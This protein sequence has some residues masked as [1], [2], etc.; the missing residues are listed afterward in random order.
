MVVAR[1]PH[2]WGRTGMGREAGSA[3]PSRRSR[4]ATAVGIFPSRPKVISRYGSSL[5]NSTCPCWRGGHSHGNWPWTPRR[6]TRTTTPSAR[7]QPS[8]WVC[9]GPRRMTSTC[10]GSTPPASAPRI[11]WNPSAAPRTPS[12][13]LPIPVTRRPT[14]TGTMPRT[15]LRRPGY[16]PNYVQNASN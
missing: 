11:S 16:P 15:G 12:P 7:R 5:R 2:R 9:I 4:R 14:C 1:R 13:R 6:V 3:V 10:A 8:S